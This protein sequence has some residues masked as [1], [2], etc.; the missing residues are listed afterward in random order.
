MGDDKD[1]EMI[2]QMVNF[3]LRWLFEVLGA[4]HEVPAFAGRRVY[5]VQLYIV[6][7]IPA[8]AGTSCNAMRINYT[9]HNLN[10]LEDIFSETEYVLRYEKGNFQ[11]GYCILN[12][13]KVAV[14]NKFYTIDGKINCL[15]DILKSFLQKQVELM[16]YRFSLILF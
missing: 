11:S 8:K 16:I 5:Y 12:E 4:L 3:Y 7:V 10:K 2:L 6:L 1:K 13:T 15:I 9:K 14:V